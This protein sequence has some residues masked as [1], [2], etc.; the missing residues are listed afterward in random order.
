MTKLQELL[1]VAGIGI[2][3]SLTPYPL[4][5][6]AALA[7]E[8]EPMRLER[9]IPINRPSQGILKITNRSLTPVQVRIQPS[10]YR[11]SQA[12]LKLN[13]PSSQ[14]WFT[15]EPDLFTL[16]PGAFSSVTYTITP[17]ANVTQDTA[18]EYLAAI[19]VDTLPVVEEPP[20]STLHPSPSR[21]TVVE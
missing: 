15:F 5:L 4:P 10:H 12:A 20:P 8:V 18:G 21:I 14:A 2:W 13:L 9:T 11:F 6:N 1:T 3:F 7:V 17:P 19:L 16:A